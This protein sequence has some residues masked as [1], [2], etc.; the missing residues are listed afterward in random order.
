VSNPS[1]FCHNCG[2]ELPLGA[3]FCPKC[4]TLVYVSPPSSTGAPPPSSSAPSPS[5]PPTYYD[6]REYRR[7]RRRQEKNEKHEKHEKGEKGEKGGGGIIGPLIGGG[8]LIWLGISFYLQQIGY[9]TSNWWAVFIVGIGLILIVQ[10]LLL[11]ARNKRPNLGPFIGGSVL[12]LI[13]LSFLYNSLGN[14]WPLILVVIGI[15]VLASAFTAR[16]RTPNPVP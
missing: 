1:K 5:Q 13:G 10:G 14:I 6:R 9:F 3:T 12:I 2:S 4:G 7:E 11:Y 16:R 8:I 15:A